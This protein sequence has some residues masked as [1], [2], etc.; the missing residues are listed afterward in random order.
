MSSANSNIKPAIQRPPN[1]QEVCTIAVIGCAFIAVLC[2]WPAGKLPD[3]VT[4]RPVAGTMTD[5]H[6]LKINSVNLMRLYIDD[7]TQT[8]RFVQHNFVD[9]LPG[10][11]KLNM[12]DK[13]IAMIS[14]KRDVINDVDEFWEIRRNGET[15]VSFPQMADCVQRREGRFRQIGYA[16]AALFLPALI[17][18]IGLR[19]RKGNWGLRQ[20]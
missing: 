11:R 1:A 12:G 19:I 10:L 4:L 14:T 7:G 9:D 17:G 5:F 13:I 18:M 15:L 3:P 8:Q 16:S 2:L 6:T 20:G